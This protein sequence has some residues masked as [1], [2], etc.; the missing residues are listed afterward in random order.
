MEFKSAK[1]AGLGI[2]YATFRNT[3][4]FSEQGQCR[5]AR[6]KEEHICQVRPVL[7]NIPFTQC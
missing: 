5:V 2:S 4:Y 6:R 3:D 7:G 1:V